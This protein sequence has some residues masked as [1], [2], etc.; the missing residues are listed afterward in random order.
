MARE[1]M[2]H[3]GVNVRRGGE[4]RLPPADARAL[5][6]VWRLRARGQAGPRASYSMSLALES[7]YRVHF[8]D[9]AL[10]GSLLPRLMTGRDVVLVTT[11]TVASLYKDSVL[12]LAR[13]YEL[14]VREVIL[15]CREE[16]KTLESVD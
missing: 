6:P 14:K 5:R 3:W 16:T 2:R 9:T 7:A 11:P 4:A 15:T 8:T 1:P 13:A 10:T 12:R